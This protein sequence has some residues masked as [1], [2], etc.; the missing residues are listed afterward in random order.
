MEYLSQP[1]QPFKEVLSTTAENLTLDYYYS[2]IGG[3]SG[4]PLKNS[5]L[6][7]KPTNLHPRPFHPRS[8]STSMQPISPP[9]RTLRKPHASPSPHVKISPAS[10]RAAVWKPH[11]ATCLTV[12]ACRDAS[13]RGRYWCPSALVWPT[14][15]FSLSPQ[16][17]TFN[18][19]SK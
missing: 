11:A 7:P 18:P 2:P 13:I 8:R 5:L 6:T 4:Q 16:V 15:P 14:T 1:P 3:P 9:R 17:Y 19:A 10:V 12:L